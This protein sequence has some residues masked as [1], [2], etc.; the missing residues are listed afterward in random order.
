MS[1]SYFFDGFLFIGL[2]II[3]LLFIKKGYSE[4]EIRIETYNKVI[5]IKSNDK[6]KKNNQIIAFKD[7]KYIQVINKLKSSGNGIVTRICE[8]NIVLNNNNRFHLVSGSDIIIMNQA[9]V[10][11]EI[12]GC[13]I[14]HDNEDQYK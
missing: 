1:N 2:S 7:I 10:V 13:D 8:L 11:A 6:T 4:K 14:Y 5:K 3:F 12:I 9:K